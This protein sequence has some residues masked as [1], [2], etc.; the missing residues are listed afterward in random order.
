MK[1][2]DWA[3]ARIAQDFAKK[4]QVKAWLAKYFG[5]KFYV[6]HEKREGWKGELPFYFFY[7]RVRDND[8]KKC[9]H[10]SYDYP[11]SWPEIQYLICHHCSKSSSC[12]SF[13]TEIKVLFKMLRI[14]LFLSFK[15]N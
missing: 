4:H 6:R 11:H 14:M 5:L 3:D 15:K 2:Y 8:G 7:C 9:G 13:I 12:V 10:F 1:D